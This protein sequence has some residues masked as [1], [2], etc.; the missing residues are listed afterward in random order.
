MSGVADSPRQ[1][2]SVV[3][4]SKQKVSVIMIKMA[5]IACFFATGKLTHTDAK[6]QSWKNLIDTSLE[7]NNNFHDFISEVEKRTES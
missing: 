5:K 7:N 6:S 2:T 1:R 4:V 3:F